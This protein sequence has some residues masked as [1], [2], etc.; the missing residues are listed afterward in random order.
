MRGYWDGELRVSDGF[1]GEVSD[2]NEI[3]IVKTVLLMGEKTFPH[4][5]RS[6]NGNISSSRVVDVYI[7][8]LAPCQ[9]QQRRAIRIL[10][11]P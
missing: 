6:K 9:H 4:E 11:L 7:D 1:N 3:D 5:K 2:V 8:C 10:N